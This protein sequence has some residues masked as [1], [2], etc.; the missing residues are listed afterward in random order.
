MH[1]TTALPKEGVASTF[2][3]NLAK[4]T[5]TAIQKWREGTEKEKHMQY[6]H[7]QLN[8]DPIAQSAL[9]ASLEKNKAIYTGENITFENNNREWIE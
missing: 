2:S 4:R 6:R 9:I 7:E 1:G 3:Q 5:V 8:Q